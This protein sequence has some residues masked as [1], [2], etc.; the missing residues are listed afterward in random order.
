MVFV[1][2]N[3][4]ST[5]PALIIAP[6]LCPFSMWNCK[7]CHY[8]ANEVSVFW[9]IFNLLVIHSHYCLVMTPRGNCNLMVSLQENLPSS[10]P[11]PII[12]PTLRPF[13]IWNCKIVTMMKMRCLCSRLSLICKFHIH[14]IVIKPRAKRNLMVSIQEDLHASV[15][16]H[17]IPP[18]A[19]PVLDM[20]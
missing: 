20:K 11:A 2:E 9:I 14:T 6:T 5:L 3:L 12:L 13:S 10:L 4:L 8:Q 7:I 16:A 17:I 18:N 19:A 1:Q 15:P